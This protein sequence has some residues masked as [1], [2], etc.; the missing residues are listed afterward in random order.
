MC[1]NPERFDFSH[2]QVVRAVILVK[3]LHMFL[4]L[5]IGDILRFSDKRDI[6]EEGILVSSHEPADG[7]AGFEHPDEFT[8]IKGYVHG[9]GHGPHVFL[10]VQ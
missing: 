4:N 9:G 10:M 3:V 8:F 6:N 7:L 2:C 5:L 1:R